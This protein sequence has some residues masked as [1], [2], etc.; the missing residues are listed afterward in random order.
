[1]CMYQLDLKYYLTIFLFIFSPKCM[2][3]FE[4]NIFQTLLPD[5]IDYP[6]DSLKKKNK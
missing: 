3:Y 4:R 2:F 1:M 5:H 6:N